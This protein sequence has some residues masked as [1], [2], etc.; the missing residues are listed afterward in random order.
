MKIFKF[1]FRPLYIR[2][3]IYAFKFKNLQAYISSNI[4]INISNFSNVNI[5]KKVHISDFTTIHVIG[6]TT[7]ANE[8]KLVIGYNTYIGEFNNI[9][10]GGGDIYIGNDC[11]IS[12]HITLVA[13]NHKFSK[14]SLIVDQEWNQQNNSIYIGDDVWIG[15]HSVILPGVKIGNGAVIGAGSI[16]TKNVDA[17]SIVVGNPAKTVG[18]RV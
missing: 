16:V 12:Q 6:N 7:N 10:A 14:N 2:Y 15:S 1:L 8:S 18:Q 5:G 17:Y 3:K 9:R 4:S 11:L 13:A